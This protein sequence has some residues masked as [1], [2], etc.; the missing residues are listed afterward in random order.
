MSY[1]LLLTFGSSIIAI[2]N[3]VLVE[4]VKCSWDVTKK[5][6]FKREVGIAIKCKKTSM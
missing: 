4:K 2:F 5:F 1:V 6:E 3:A